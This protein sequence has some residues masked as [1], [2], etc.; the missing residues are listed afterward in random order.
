MNSPPAVSAVNEAM[1][2]RL[3][4]IHGETL[5]ESQLSYCVYEWDYR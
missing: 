4:D 1:K 2:T 5:S 3:A